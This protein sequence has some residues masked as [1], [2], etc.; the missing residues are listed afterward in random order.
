MNKLNQSIKLNDLLNKNWNKFFLIYKVEPFFYVPASQTVSAF[1]GS[2]LKI[3]FE[4]LYGY[5]SSEKIKWEWKKLEE[6]IDLSNRV[7]LHADP[8]NQT[9]WLAIRE[10]I[11][12]DEGTYV[13]TASNQYGNNSQQIMLYV[14]SSWSYLIPLIIIII[15]ICVLILILVSFENRKKKS[16]QNCL[17]ASRTIFFIFLF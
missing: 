17:F 13:C 3:E 7:V 14:K 16:N 8:S 1:I 9:S 15:E 10:V 6:T 2:E 5:E 12:A 11:K 4:L